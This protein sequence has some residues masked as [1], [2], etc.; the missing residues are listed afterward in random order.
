L[1]S[2]LNL[3]LSLPMRV[4]QHLLRLQ[5]LVRLR[6]LSKHQLR[7]RQPQLPHQLLHLQHLQQR[8]AEQSS[9]CLRSV[10]Q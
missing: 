9:Q 4:H 3:Q 1:L 6:L 8:L 10:N 2:A 7:Q 5:L